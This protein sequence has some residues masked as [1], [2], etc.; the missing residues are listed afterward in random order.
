MS[1]AAP[2]GSPASVVGPVASKTLAP[3]GQPHDLV[4][5]IRAEP[6]ALVYFLL[7]VGDGD[8]QLLLLPADSRDAVRRLVIVDVATTGKLPPLLDELHK[9]GLIQQPGTRG[10]VPLLVATHPHFDHIG[11]ISDLLQHLQA[12]PG[13]VEQFWDP[14][15][16]SPNPS[17]LNPHAPA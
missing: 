16:Y 12:E 15:F 5:A 9:H 14:G 13:C 10:Q 7:N 4:E 17:F 1:T 6:G 2:V 11:G 3:A 8:T